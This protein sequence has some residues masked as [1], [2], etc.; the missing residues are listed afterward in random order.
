MEGQIRNYSVILVL[1]KIDLHQQNQ[2][3]ETNVQSCQQSF[4]PLETIKN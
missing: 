3:N 4:M 1:K 2:Q